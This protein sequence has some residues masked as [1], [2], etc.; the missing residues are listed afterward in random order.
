[1]V[2][3]E[4]P[5]K[6]VPPVIVWPPL[7]PNSSSKASRWQKTFATS[8]CALNREKFLMLTVV[9][10]TLIPLLFLFQNLFTEADGSG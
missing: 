5:S 7:N 8:E 4:L 2:K 10:L 9:I 1:M 6:T 3:K